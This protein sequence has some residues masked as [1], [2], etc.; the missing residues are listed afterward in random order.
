VDVAADGRK[1]T[2]ADLEAK[3]TE[4]DAELNDTGEAIKPKALAFG[5][6]A[7]VVILLLAFLLGRRK[8][9]RRSTIVEVRRI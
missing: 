9:E 6:G 8:G 3:L 1:I 4:I 2:R 7:L 5:V